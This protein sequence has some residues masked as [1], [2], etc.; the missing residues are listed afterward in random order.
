MPGPGSVA[1]I[2][3][4]RP[5]ADEPDPEAPKD[6]TTPTLANELNKK[7][8]AKKKGAKKK[9]AKK[10]GAKKKGAKKKAR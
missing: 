8:G 2:G 6:S 9:G 7:K 5:A 3:R 4:G 10:K 1:V